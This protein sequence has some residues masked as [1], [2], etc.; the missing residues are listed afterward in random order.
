[1]KNVFSILCM[2]LLLASCSEKEEGEVIHL[3]ERNGLM[4]ESNR[5][6]P[7]TGKYIEYSVFGQEKKRAEKITRMA[8]E[9]DSRPFGM[10]VDRCSQKQ[11]TRAGNKMELKLFGI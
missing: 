5:E 9:T 3:Q 11:P 1:M 4:F 2:V 7:F 6:K 10:K 8:R